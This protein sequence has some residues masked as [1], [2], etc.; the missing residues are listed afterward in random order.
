MISHKNHPFRDIFKFLYLLLL[1]CIQ[2]I[3]SIYLLCVISKITNC[4]VMIIKQSL[5]KY[6]FGKKLFS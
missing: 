4:L 5:V 2:K 6:G 3:D 1:N